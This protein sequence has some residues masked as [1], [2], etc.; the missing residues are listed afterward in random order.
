MS[1]SNI[2]EID[3]LKIEYRFEGFLSA[4]NSLKDFLLFG[5]RIR[6]LMI[7]YVGLPLPGFL[8]P[9][10]IV[11]FF[12]LVLFGET[13]KDS[14]ESLKYLDIIQSIILLLL[15]CSLILPIVSSTI[16][17]ASISGLIF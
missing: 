16:L 12:L 9:F 2:S 5:F 7:L 3:A 13:K 10:C 8:L 14:F 6:S 4:T 15:S 11:V 1:D 17:S